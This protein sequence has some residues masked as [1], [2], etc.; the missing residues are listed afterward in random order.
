LLASGTPQAYYHVNANDLVACRWQG[1]FTNRNVGRRNIH[2][3]VSIF[4]IIMMVFRVVGI[5]I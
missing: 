5:E 4:E 1:N 3:L 2:Q